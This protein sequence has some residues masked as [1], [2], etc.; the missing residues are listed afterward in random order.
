M[1]ENITER[2]PV[3]DLD[4][5]DEDDGT[6]PKNVQ[7]LREQV[8]GRRIISAVEGKAQW[9]RPLQWKW[10]EPWVIEEDSGLILTLDDGKKVLLADTNDCCA[11]TEIEKFMLNLEHIDHVIT[12]VGTTERYQRWHIYADYGDMLQLEIGWSPGNPFYYG[13]G[14][15]IQVIDEIIEVKHD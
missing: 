1:I 7:Q 13:Y 11:Y 6:M 5:E 2:Y 14:L 15:D 9:K 4:G 3:E 12:G 8:I 10:P